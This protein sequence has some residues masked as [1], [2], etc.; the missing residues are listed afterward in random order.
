[1]LLKEC[2]RCKRL[3]PYGLTYCE[4]CAP[5]VQAEREA[6]QLESK[7]ERNRKYNK[8][9]DK[10]YIRFY[11]SVAWKTLSAKRLQ[12]DGYKCVKC[13]KIA[14]EVDHIIPIQTDDGWEKRLDYS[15]T[16]SLCLECHNKKHNRF[17]KKET[18]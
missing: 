1:M 3:I 18:R 5:I 7:R 16:Q 17:I 6:R 4:D 12:D 9:R 10:K 2:Y 11:G 8:N 15:N 14:S 13:G